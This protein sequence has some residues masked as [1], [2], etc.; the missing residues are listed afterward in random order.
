M[1]KNLE[2]KYRREIRL[3]PWNKFLIII[4]L[5]CESQSFAITNTV[6]FRAVTFNLYNSPSERQA[7][8]QNA[9]QVLKTLKPDIIALQEVATGLILPGNPVELFAESLSMDSRIQYQQN[10]FFLFKTGLAILSKFP[11]EEA[12]YFEFSNHAPFDAKGFLFVKVKSPSGVFG[13][14]NVHLASTDN[15]KM[16][17]SEFAELG[18]FVLKKSAEH[19]LVVLGDF[20]EDFKT[21]LFQEFSK[22]ISGDVLF[23]HLPHEKIHNT[24]SE[25]YRDSCSASNG[26]RIDTVL[27]VDK[28]AE[29]RLFFTEGSIIVPKMMPHP[30]DHCPV[31]ADLVLKKS[32]P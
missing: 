26:E 30:S 31:V 2:L 22:R 20:N 27:K 13:V 25:S 28:Q 19:P 29:I 4:Y 10:K 23:A 32:G 17:K 18:N 1:F 6:P 11:I 14:V 3:R 21:P 9:L 5:L 12:E 16:K 24:W 7:R 15:Q 8:L